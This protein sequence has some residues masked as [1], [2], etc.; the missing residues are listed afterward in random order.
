ML[1]LNEKVYVKPRHQRIMVLMIADPTHT[2]PHNVVW[3]LGKAP[4]KHRGGDARDAVDPISYLLLYGSIS[5]SMT[6]QLGT[7]FAK[8]LKHFKH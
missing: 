8:I 6:L 2:S 1:T 5:I 7:Y 3:I 4:K